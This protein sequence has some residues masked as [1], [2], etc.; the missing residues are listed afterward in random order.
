MRRSPL[1]T[2]LLM[3]VKRAIISKIKTFVYHGVPHSK[4]SLRSRRQKRFRRQEWIGQRSRRYR[5]TTV[6]FYMA[7]GSVA[8]TWP[9]KQRALLMQSLIVTYT[10]SR[11]LVSM[12]FLNSS[13][14][15]A[16]APVLLLSA[17][18]RS[19]LKPNSQNCFDAAFLD[20]ICSVS[21]VVSLTV[22]NKRKKSWQKYHDYIL[23]A[24]DIN[25][26]GNWVLECSLQE[27]KS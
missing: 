21:P 5:Y 20:N 23:S 25:Q 8:V 14:N 19:S 7:L 27:H 26:C 13:R 17:S 24:R 4:F 6:T 22:G 18:M 16:N 2:N 9:T 3:S 15:Y 1:D 12:I 11:H 10:L